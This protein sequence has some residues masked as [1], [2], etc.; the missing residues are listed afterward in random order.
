MFLPYI[1]TLVYRDA[2]GGGMGIGRKY[3]LC[4][5]DLLPFVPLPF[6]FPFLTSYPLHCVWK[7]GEQPGKVKLENL[8]THPNLLQR[9]CRDKSLLMTVVVREGVSWGKRFLF[10]FWEQLILCISRGRGIFIMVL[11]FLLDILCSYEVRW[12]IWNFLF[13]PQPLQ[14]A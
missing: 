9:M 3:A 4:W 13:F 8:S 1:L 7:S 12:V 5:L 10:G 6:V 11:D 14:I 2:A